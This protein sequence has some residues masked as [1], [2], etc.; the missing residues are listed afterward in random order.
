[1]TVQDGSLSSTKKTP[2][3]ERQSPK[4]EKKGEKNTDSQV[5]KKAKV[6]TNTNIKGGG[7]APSNV[8]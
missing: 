3:S 8:L 6:T 7:I 5:K 2:P 4:G 1:M